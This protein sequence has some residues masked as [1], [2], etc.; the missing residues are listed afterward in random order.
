M[1]KDF[2]YACV[3]VITRIGVSVIAY[4]FR[5]AR[6]GNYNAEVLR[7]LLYVS[8]GTRLIKIEMYIYKEGVLRSKLSSYVRNYGTSL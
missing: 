4:D 1:Y 2:Y 6:S 5:N 7:D 3:Y 8:A